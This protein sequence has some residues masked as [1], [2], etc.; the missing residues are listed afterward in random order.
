LDQIPDEVFQCLEWFLGDPSLDPPG[1]G[2]VRAA[3]ACGVLYGTAISAV[4]NP[5]ARPWTGA[6]ITNYGILALQKRGKIIGETPSA[7]GSGGQTVNQAITESGPTE[8]ARERKEVTA[9]QANAN[10]DQEVSKLAAALG[11]LAIHPEWSD[12][13]IAA[14]VGC[15]GAYLSQQSKWRAARKAIRGVGQEAR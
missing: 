14:A 15:S 11:M 13:K 7:P 10:K 9:L 4:L 2:T 3:V 5:H 1:M 8:D 6:F 12:R